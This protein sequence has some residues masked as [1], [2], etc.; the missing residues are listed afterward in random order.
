MFVY[1]DGRRQNMFMP[2]Q[3]KP[4]AAFIFFS[5]QD[6]S[7]TSETSMSGICSICKKIYIHVLM[8]F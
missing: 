6:I 7:Y 8:K 1:S 2:Q 4:L 3:T 5:W